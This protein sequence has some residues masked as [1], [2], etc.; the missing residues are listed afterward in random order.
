MRRLRPPARV[1]A[2][3]RRPLARQHIANGSSP[4]SSAPLARPS[5][6]RL[7]TVAEAADLQ[8]GQPV[9]ET[10][11]H[12]LEAGERASFPSSSFHEL[13]LPHNLVFHAVQLANLS[14]T[15]TPGITAQ[16]YADRRASL[17]AQLPLGA[18][19]LLPA[20]TLKYRSGAVFYPYRQDS[21][22]LYL[23]GWKE[24]D[25]LAVVE[26]TGPNLGDYAFRLFCRDKSPREER[27]EGP[28]NG[29]A[30]ARDVFNADVAHDIRD[31]GRVLPA[32]LQAATAVYTD[33]DPARI[34]VADGG[35]A[36][37]NTGWRRLLSGTAAASWF[38]KRHKPLRPLLNGL[39]AVKSPAEIANMRRAGQLSGRVITDAMRRRPGWAREKDLHA[40]LD[41][42]FTAAGCDG[43]AYVPVVAGGRNALTIHYVLNDMALR[44]GDLVQID[45]GG[46]YGTYVCDI[47]RV[48]PVAG[49]RSWSA[50]QRDLYEAVL[51]VQR[52]CVSLCRA[53][54]NLSLDDLHAVAERGLL[55]QLQR[56]GFDGLTPA[57][58][59]ELFPHHLGHYLGLDI[60]D[61]PGYGRNIALRQGHCIA[62]EPGVYVPADDER[63]P[64]H[65][66]GLGVRIED[67]VCVDDDSPIVLTAEA[68]KEI[69][70][71]EALWD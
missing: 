1:L 32:I 43:P 58:V 69:D 20:A 57:G 24:G 8:F 13:D 34:P 16:E 65:F 45:A 50:A 36:A 17:A 42:G 66:R 67:S 27:W 56:L 10:H 5:V 55:D 29:V 37:G 59:K 28:R 46:E 39:R 33:V 15:V 41:Y 38:P 64:A 19:A 6:R 62:V 4:A 18:V 3:L 60:H 54:A 47:S 63:W 53:S 9:H 25:S 51:R 61:V 31:A 23:T 48:W 49:P 22:F 21:D 11:P 7:A 12:I 2:S 70:D 26:N 52:S 71:I 40:F 14:K 68:V 35:A 44:A 30:A